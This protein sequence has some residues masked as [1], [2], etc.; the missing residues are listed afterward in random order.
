[1]IEELIMRI[2]TEWGLIYSLFSMIIIGAIWKWIPFIVDK[3]ESMI[4]NFTTSL[5]RQEEMF[6]STLDNIRKDFINQ[7]KDS[8][9]WHEKH[10]KQLEE[11]NKTLNNIQNLLSKKQ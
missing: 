2:F 7:I 9:I 1:M 3:F 5:K 10:Q 11:Y 8:N 4:E 6:K